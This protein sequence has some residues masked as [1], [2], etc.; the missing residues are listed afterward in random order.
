[1]MYSLC[2]FGDLPQDGTPPESECEWLSLP[3]RVR[4]QRAGCWTSVPHDILNENEPTGAT[5]HSVSSY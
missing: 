3:A 5:G 4:V 1:M 2:M